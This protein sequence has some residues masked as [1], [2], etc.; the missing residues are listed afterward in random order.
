MTTWKPDLDAR[1]HHDP[2]PARTTLL[3]QNAASRAGSILHLARLSG[4]SPRRLNYLR[5]GSRVL[6]DGSELPVTIRFA[7][8][9]L[10]ETIA[11]DEETIPG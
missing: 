2:D 8:Q 4:I 5:S 11:D 9:V 7:E 6:P 1:K 10:L 3:V